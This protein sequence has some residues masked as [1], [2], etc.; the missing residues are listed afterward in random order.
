MGTNP[1]AT[2][3]FARPSLVGGMASIFDLGGTLVEYNNSPSTNI[4]DA[5][6]IRMDW[7]AVGQDLRSAMRSVKRGRHVKAP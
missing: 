6:A 4:A 1:Y 7:A 3:L 5:T 2:F